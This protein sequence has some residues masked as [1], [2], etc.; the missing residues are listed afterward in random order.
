MTTAT[1]MLEQLTASTGLDTAQLTLLAALGLA[2]LLLMLAIAGAI[3]R[4]RAADRLRAELALSRSATGA[5]L[6]ELKGRLAILA[7]AT[8]QRQSELAST[9]H[10]RLDHVSDRV[11]EGLQAVSE[12]LGA[13]LESVSERL[14]ANLAE[15]SL[16]LGTNLTE[17]QGRTA[18]SLSK[19]YERLALIDRASASLDQLSSTVVGLKDV[20]ANKQTRG[21][22]GQMRMESI[23]EDGLPRSLYE[24][25]ATLSNGTRPDCLI[26]I[27]SA[28]AP[29]VVDAKFPL[30]GFEAL[31]LAQ[32]PELAPASARIRTDIG[33]HIDEIAG[34][35]LIA[36]ETQD[37]ALMF[38]PSE[39]VYAELHERFPDLVQRAHRARVVIVSPNM[40]MLAVQTMQAIL[41]DV[42]M[43]EQ[44]GLIQREVALMIGDVGRLAER[45][46]DLEK[47]FTLAAKDVEKILVSTE[48]VIG[49][50]RRIEAAEV[51]EAMA[52]EI[53]TAA[54]EERK[55]AAGA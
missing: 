16:R 13:S 40:L 9:L 8:S 42:R 32:G 1:D 7:E 45:V 10:Q 21:A 51:G 52:A 53:A 11:G 38:V 50:G 6:A 5:E 48:R 23:I 19:L 36:G 30:E 3:L 31:R 33:R 20:L 28:P 4:Q 49:R 47:H 27:P 18:D 29:L 26:R 35:Y 12:R 34:K 37:T 46:R 17:Q 39:S 15:T 43:R 2:A 25:Q 22:F 24:F 14:G 55:L 44:A 54:P 41:K